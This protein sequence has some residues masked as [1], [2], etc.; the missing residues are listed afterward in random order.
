MV[1]RGTWSYSDGKR[2]NKLSS[3]KITDKG[4]SIGYLGQPRDW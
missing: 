2:W 4:A 1:I 3:I